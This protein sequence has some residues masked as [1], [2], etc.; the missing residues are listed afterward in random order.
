MKFSFD[1]QTFFNFFFQDHDQDQDSSMKFINRKLCSEYLRYPPNL[2]AYH[3]VF[4]KI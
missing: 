3:K 1:P 2:V 4:V